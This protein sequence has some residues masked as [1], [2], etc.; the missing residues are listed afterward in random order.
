MA[1]QS[2]LLGYN[3]NVRHNDKLYHIQTEDSG[4]KRPHVITH[5]FADGGR[6]VA[7]RKTSYAEHVGA[8]N[9]AE[10]V[11]NL[12]R[13]Q[14]KGMFI[15]LRDGEFDAQEAEA[16]RHM[17]GAAGTPRAHATEP[18]GPPTEIPHL[19]G[20]GVPMTLDEVILSYLAED[21]QAQA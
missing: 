11:K 12:M 17:A 1:V 2:P 7:S 13:E 4:I 18:A 16:E 15:S 19:K 9:V 8:E 3:T 10:I 14:H 5:L 21:L 20:S 6:I